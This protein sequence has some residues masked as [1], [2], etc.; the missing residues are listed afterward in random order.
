MASRFEI[1]SDASGKFHFQL[2]GPDGAVLLTSE[3]YDGKITTQNAVLHARTALKDEG[4]LA[5]ESGAQG[6]RRLVLKDKDD[7]LLARSP[8]NDPAAIATLRGTIRTIAATA[9]IVDLTKRRPA[10]TA[11]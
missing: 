5:E 10:S 3:G 8:A 4:R 2:R 9:P 11:P 6:Q 1:V 7:S